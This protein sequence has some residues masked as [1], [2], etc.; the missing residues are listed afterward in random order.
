MTNEIS[1]EIEM[2]HTLRVEPKRGAHTPDF[3]YTQFD[4][5]HISV[6]VKRMEYLQNNKLK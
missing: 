3:G 1:L 5:N 6:Y 2:N 4:S